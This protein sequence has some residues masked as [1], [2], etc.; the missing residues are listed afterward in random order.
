MI[1]KRKFLN[2]LYDSDSWSGHF[3]VEFLPLQNDISFTLLCLIVGVGSISR[4]FLVHQK[5]NN[6]VARCYFFE[7]S[8]MLGAI[9]ARWYF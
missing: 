5:A 9:F 2:L 3:K 8:F 6:V 4:E 1:F 7:M